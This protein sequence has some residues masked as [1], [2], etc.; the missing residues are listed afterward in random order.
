[1]DSLFLELI[2]IVGLNNAIFSA[3][4]LSCHFYIF[5]LYSKR[6]QDRKTEIDRLAAENQQYRDRFFKLIDSKY[7]D[8]KEGSK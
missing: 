6:L 3:I 1:M 8:Q 2:K 5:R 4:V 7:S